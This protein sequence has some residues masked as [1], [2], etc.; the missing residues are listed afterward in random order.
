VHAARGVL[1]LDG[2]VVQ[3]GTATLTTKDAPLKTLIGLDGS[4]YFSDL[5]AGNYTLQAETANGDLTC[6]FTMPSNTR[7][8]TNLSKIACIRSAGATP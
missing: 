7:L 3:Y 8:L 4:F 1:M 2:K 6:R 5:P